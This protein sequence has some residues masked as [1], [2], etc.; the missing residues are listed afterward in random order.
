M[1]ELLLEA[2]EGDD[3]RFSKVLNKWQEFFLLASE[4][5]IYEKI[6]EAQ[7]ELDDF[8]PHTGEL[9]VYSGIALYPEVQPDD[10]IETVRGYVEDNVA[11]SAGVIISDNDDEPPSIHFLFH[12]WSVT[13]R[14][15]P[16]CIQKRDFM[17]YLE[18]D[19]SVIPI[20]KIEEAFNEDTPHNI[21]SHE[22]DVHDYLSRAS[23]NL[24][25]LLRSTTFRR[26]PRQKQENIVNN[27][28]QNAEQRSSL[29]G[30]KILLEGAIAYRPRLVDNKLDYDCTVI[31]EQVI[32]AMC[33]GLTTLETRKLSEK[34]IRR[35][36]DMI[37]RDSGLCLLIEDFTGQDSEVDEPKGDIL[38][39]PISGQHLEVALDT[40]YDMDS[41]PDQSME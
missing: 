20:E 1:N 29:K 26:M 3:E 38:L 37:S 24:V 14:L 2:F 18:A 39:V 8:W 16:T 25:V 41:P 36:L 6:S 4:D 15:G 19:G 34:A 7:Q 40:V 33:H 13:E 5:E 23:D 22:P 11:V 28:V 17:S 12:L 32:S 35:D 10:S 9:C 27:Y 31:S 21:E 30:A